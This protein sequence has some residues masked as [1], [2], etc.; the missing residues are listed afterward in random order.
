MNV[1]E[2]INEIKEEGYSKPQVGLITPEIRTID[3]YAK[4]SVRFID[5]EEENKE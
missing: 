3:E 5:L 1:N 4:R 2:L